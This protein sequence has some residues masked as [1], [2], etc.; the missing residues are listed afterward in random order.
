MS[1]NVNNLPWEIR[2]NHMPG[3]DYSK[4]LIF[5]NGQQIAF[6]SA[7]LSKTEQEK[8]TKEIVN[9]HNNNLPKEKEEIEGLLLTVNASGLDSED[10]VVGLEEVVKKV[11]DGFSSGFDEGEDRDYDFE[12]KG[13]T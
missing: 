13:Y 7:C 9:N 3:Q 8:M 12:I 11:R 10:L 1:S 6:V 4:N 2:V 5:C